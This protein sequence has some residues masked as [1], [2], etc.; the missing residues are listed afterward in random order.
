MLV[1]ALLFLLAPLAPLSFRRPFSIDF[2]IISN[3]FSQNIV[4]ISHIMGF[5]D[6]PGPVLLSKLIICG[7]CISKTNKPGVASP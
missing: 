5:L 7:S 3:W 4:K 6:Y 1:G 2:L